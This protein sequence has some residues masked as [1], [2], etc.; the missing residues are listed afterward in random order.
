MALVAWRWNR[1]YSYAA[2]YRARG[3]SEDEIREGDEL[4]P[5]MAAEYSSNRRHFGDPAYGSW[6][7]YAQ[8]PIKDKVRA[9]LR[10]KPSP[11]RRPR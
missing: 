4:G 3:F 11:R 6:P 7:D 10:G 1:Q 5:A 2:G 9:M 8:Q